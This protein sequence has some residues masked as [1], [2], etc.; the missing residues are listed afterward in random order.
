EVKLTFLKCQTQA[1]RISY[2]GYVT[3]QDLPTGFS[4]AKDPALLRQEIS[5]LRSKLMAIFGG[6]LELN[7]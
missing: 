6:K 2:S 1:E 3:A 7:P 4:K 5:A